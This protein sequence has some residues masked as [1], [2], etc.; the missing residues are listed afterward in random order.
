MC[1]LFY[2]CSFSRPI[3]FS[4]FIPSLPEKG[5]WYKTAQEEREKKMEGSEVE[6]MEKEGGV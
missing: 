2:F 6:K 3:L 4:S 1:A 5:E